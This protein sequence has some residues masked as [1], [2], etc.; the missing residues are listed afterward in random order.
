MNAFAAFD[1]AWIVHQDS[2]VLV[3]NKPAGVPC[4]APRQGIVD[5]LPSRASKALGQ[6]LKVHQRLDAATSGLIVYSLSDAATRSLAAQ[7]ESRSVKKRYL[8]AANWRGNGRVLD[9]RLDGK[10]ART[11][12][13]VLSRRGDRALLSATI[14]TGRRHQI[15][16]HLADAGA[17][18]AGDLRY[19]GPPAPHLLLQSETLEIHQGRWSLP[20]LPVF[21]HWLEGEDSTPLDE[22]GALETRLRGAAQQRYWLSQTSTTCFR[23]AN[24]EGD[25]LRG[26]AVDVYGDHFVLHLYDEGSK[27]EAT[28]LDALMRLGPGGIYVKRR[29]R[30]ANELVE[31]GERAPAGPLRG[32]PAPDP[33]IVHEEDVAYSVRLGDGLSTGLFLDQ[34][35]ARRR[36]RESAKGKSVLN[37]FAYTGGFS[38]AAAVGGANRVASVDASKGALARAEAAMHTLGFAD[39]ETW[40]HDCF[41]ALAIL[42]KRGD[43]FDI[44]VADPPTYSRVKKK[45]WTSGKDWTRLAEACFHVCERGATL[46]LSSNDSRMSARAFRRFVHEGARRA[47]VE[48]QSLRDLPDPP[49]FPAREAALKRL[50]VTLLP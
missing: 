11:E 14:E 31:A 17:P 49:D 9:G 50:W 10:K 43:R 18:V 2:H 42:K 46:L 45:R 39:H 8:V 21:D 24:G 5:D 23:L 33:L 30:Q 7:F 19:G 26:F 12:V 32:V 3:L 20:A 28:I 48:I 22:V 15:R 36:V 13:E 25:G 41:D 37:L 16:R 47:N 6:T 27:H 34:R 29:P 38:I 40:R 44:V 1:P 35:D 4:M